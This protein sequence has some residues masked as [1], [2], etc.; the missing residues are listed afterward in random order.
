VKDLPNRDLLRVKHQD[1]RWSVKDFKK[2]SD[3][4]MYGLSSLGCRPGDAVG[5]ILGNN[6]EH[7]VLLY[8]AARLGLTVAPFDENMVSKKDLE[9]AIAETECRVLLIGNAED[10]LVGSDVAKTV[11]DI[12]P[13][14]NDE[15]DG[16]TPRVKDDRFPSL[17]HVMSTEY[18]KVSGSMLQFRHFLAYE[19][20]ARNP[21]SR[22]KKFV[23][24]KTPLIQPVSALGQ[25]TAVTH[26]EL[27]K[28][29]AAA[30]ASLGV[31]DGDKLLLESRDPVDLAV[32][33]FL[34]CDTLC[35][36]V[37]TDSKNADDVELYEVEGCTKRVTSFAV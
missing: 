14:L 11:R 7:A 20:L 28:R 26:G 29:A 30:K 17:E 35:P 6:T 13:Q 19:V 27:S 5:A 36:L 33:L 34:S 21:G 24:E 1:V 15:I 4:F 8:A 2:H 23:S 9:K 3:A 25:E 18:Y 32:G 22:A 31:T 12:L 10:Q 37:L 16:T